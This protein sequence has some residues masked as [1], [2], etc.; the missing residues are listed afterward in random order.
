MKSLFLAAAV[1]AGLTFSAS[2]ADAQ[3]IYQ[4]GYT[5]SVPAYG[6]SYAYPSYYGVAPYGYVST[7]PVSGITLTSGYPPVVTSYSPPSY[8]GTGYSGTYTA[9]GY[10]G[11]YST[12]GYYRGLQ[13]RGWRW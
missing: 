1:A 6:Y 13:G 10:Y 7:Y 8:Y 12:P 11:T 4:S 9:P 2:H 5:Y 3:Y